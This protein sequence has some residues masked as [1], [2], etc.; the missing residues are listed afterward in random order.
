MTAPL[1]QI[2]PVEVVVILMSEH[3]ADRARL[4]ETSVEIR[5]YPQPN[6]DVIVRYRV[7][8]RL[9]PENRAFRRRI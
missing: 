8:H 6:I 2:K 1:A 4:Q 3:E 9:G 5:P 7:Q